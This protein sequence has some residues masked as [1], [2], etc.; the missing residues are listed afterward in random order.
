MRLLR[1]IWSALTAATT[2]FIEPKAWLS[3]MVVVVVGWWWWWLGGGGGGVVVVGGGGGGEAQ[4]LVVRI[5]HVGVIKHRRS[6]NRNTRGAGISPIDPNQIPSAHV[7]N[8]SGQCT[9]EF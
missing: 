3:P 6:Q 7:L 1:Q 4:S 9:G 8:S 5:F 2:T